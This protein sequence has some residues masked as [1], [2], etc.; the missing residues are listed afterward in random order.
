MRRPGQIALLRFPQSDL[1]LGK[2]RPVVLLCRAPGPF[3]D[4]LV[5]MVSSQLRQAV[6]GFDEVIRESDE[7]FAQSGLKTTSVFRISRLAIVEASVLLGAIGEVSPT[8]LRQIR[9]RVARWVEGPQQA[10][11]EPVP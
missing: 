2:L 11:N 9:A 5:C 7:D 10:A 3:D 8:R 1:G 4:W 6:T